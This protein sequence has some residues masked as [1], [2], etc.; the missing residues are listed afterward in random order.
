VRIEQAWNCPACGAELSA[1]SDLPEDLAEHLRR[2]DE[3]IGEVHIRFHQETQ[4]SIRAEHAEKCRVSNSPETDVAV[5]SSPGGEAEAQETG[6][7][8]LPPDADASETEEVKP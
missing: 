1:A 5:D 4:D 7:D 2:D 8:G 6:V 3:S